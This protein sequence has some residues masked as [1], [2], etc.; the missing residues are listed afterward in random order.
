[1]ARKLVIRLSYEDDDDWRN[2]LHAQRVILS[3]EI[4]TLRGGPKPYIEAEAGRMW[5]QLKA[6]EEADR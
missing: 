1:M 2:V 5:E 3:R 4:E 6:A